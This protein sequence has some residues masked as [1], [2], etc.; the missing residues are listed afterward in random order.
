[1]MTGWLSN[2]GQMLGLGVLSNLSIRLGVEKS[3]RG[4]YR[5]TVEDLDIFTQFAEMP[6]QG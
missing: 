3:K 2:K 6:G 5:I 1:L 4:R